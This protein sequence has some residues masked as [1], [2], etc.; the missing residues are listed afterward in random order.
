MSQRSLHSFQTSHLFQLHF[1]F[2]MTNENC[3]PLLIVS[4]TIVHNLL[5]SL[6]SIRIQ[7]FHGRIVRSEPIIKFRNEKISHDLVKKK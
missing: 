2:N 1:E 3:G 5:F 7:R 4:S 6:V